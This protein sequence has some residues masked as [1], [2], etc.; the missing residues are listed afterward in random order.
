MNRGLFSEIC[1]LPKVLLHVEQQNDTGLNVK[2]CN[3][4]Y[5]DQYNSLRFKCTRVTLCQSIFYFSYWCAIC[6]FYWVT[7]KLLPEGPNVLLLGICRGNQLLHMMKRD[8]QTQWS[9]RF[10]RVR[11]VDPTTLYDVVHCRALVHG[12]ETPVAQRQNF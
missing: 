1:F 9:T 8:N 3:E 7:I 12:P 2:Y 11:S 4:T 10:R 6:P 5:T